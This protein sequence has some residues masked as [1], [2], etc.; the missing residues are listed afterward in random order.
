MQGKLK[1]F[2]AR[3][4]QQQIS[5]T[6]GLREVKRNFIP[7]AKP[8]AGGA[9]GR[10]IQSTKSALRYIFHLRT[11]TDEV[12]ATSLAQVENLLNSR[13]LTYLSVNPNDPEPLTPNHLLLGRASPNHPPDV[14]C[15]DPPSSEDEI[16]SRKRWR[17]AQA[18]ATHFRRRWLKKYLPG[19]TERKKCRRSERN[20]SVGDIVLVITPSTD[21]GHWQLGRIVEICKGK[22]GVVRFAYV[23]TRVR[24]EAAETQALHR[25]AM[26][27]CPLLLDND[28]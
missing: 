4:N 16:N 6:L 15:Q 5:S 24:P 12:L 22:G 26:K 28:G 18:I 19:F 8:H 7:P 14:I 3:L 1:Q 27:L 10:L 23:K 20:L 25:P 17:Q 9:W 21:R 11:I 2:L 13:P